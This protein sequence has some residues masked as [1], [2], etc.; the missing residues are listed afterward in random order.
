VQSSLVEVV[1]AESI[2]SLVVVVVLVEESLVVETSAMDDLVVCILVPL[3]VAM[4][5]GI[6]SSKF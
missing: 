2:P 6:Y 4:V 1:E 3:L 5:M